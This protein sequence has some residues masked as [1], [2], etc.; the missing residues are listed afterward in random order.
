MVC[1]VRAQLAVALQH[2]ARVGWGRLLGKATKFLSYLNPQPSKKSR[3]VP[4]NACH[5]HA[6]RMPPAHNTSPIALLASLYAAHTQEL[7]LA[8]SGRDLTINNGSCHTQ[9]LSNPPLLT[10]SALLVQSVYTGAAP[11]HLRP[12][13]PGGLAINNSSLHTQ[14]LCNAPHLTAPALLVQCLCRS[15][16]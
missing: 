3:M 10:T 4:D 15:C 8:T 12:Q 14:H 1:Q 7:P 9:H 16:P 2:K 6:V 5:N 11:S 13:L